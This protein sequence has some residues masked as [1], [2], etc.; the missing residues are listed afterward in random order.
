MSADNHTP[1][2]SLEHNTKT[3]STIREFKQALPNL[4]LPHDSS[5][6]L[7]LLI[8]CRAKANILRHWLQSNTCFLA[9]PHGHMYAWSDR[10]LSQDVVYLD[11]ELHTHGK[12]R[13]LYVKSQ[14]PPKIRSV[15][16]LQSPH[17]PL[18]RRR[19]GNLIAGRALGPVCCTMCYF[20]SD[21]GG[22]RGVAALIAALVKEQPASDLPFECLPRALVVVESASS[23]LDCTT[24]KSE[25]L[26]D[27]A[28]LMTGSIDTADS[29]NQQI[30]QHFY[31]ID[32]L[33]V[34]RRNAHTRTEMV[35]NR[36]VDLIRG[37]RAARLSSGLLFRRDHVYELAGKLLSHFCL[38]PATAFSFASSS[39]PEGLNL[40][41]FSHHIRE[42]I[43]IV[44][45]EAWLWHFVCPLL[46]S[47]ILLANYPPDSHCK[48]LRFCSQTT[49]HI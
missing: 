22:I 28:D 44:P 14:A 31:C 48:S 3:S 4:R 45:A 15:D 8:G 1:W 12:A 43:A 40:Q 2:L 11:F 9:N 34:Q 21:L 47:A 16:W 33:C 10:M 36:F 32:V 49:T 7:V 23:Q 39:R 46:A 17:G 37:W 35:R 19:V 13:Q 42:A 26:C 38:H 41:F 18:T 6:A 30:E 5:P 24:A 29:L 20:A 27:L 25:L